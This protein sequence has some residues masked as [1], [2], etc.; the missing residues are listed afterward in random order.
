MA[1]AALPREGEPWARGRGPLEQDSRNSV[2]RPSPTDPFHKKTGPGIHGP[3]WRVS[4]TGRPT[5]LQGFS[6]SS[7]ARLLL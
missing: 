7:L 4:Y 5:G 1:L 2:V 3:S 6:F